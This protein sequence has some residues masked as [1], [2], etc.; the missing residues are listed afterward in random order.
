MQQSV[1]VLDRLKQQL[2]RHAR[3]SFAA[4]ERHRQAIETQ[5][6]ATEDEL[7]ASRHQPPEE[8][9][10]WLAEQHS[11]RLR[12]ELKRR[13]ENA[14][15]DRQGQV[16]EKHRDALRVATQEARLMEILVEQQVSE[17]EEQRRRRESH[18]LDD[19]AMARWALRC[20]G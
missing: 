2:K 10:L 19:L 15:L 4:Q 7:D 14:L 12:L 6:E 11:H 8:E 13:Q 17:E 1:L 20:A 18:D 16:V 3:L 9:V 5:L